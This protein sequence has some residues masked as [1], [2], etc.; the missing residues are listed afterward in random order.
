MLELIWLRGVGGNVLSG[1]GASG[2]EELDW[3]GDSG[4]D[5]VSSSSTGDSVFSLGV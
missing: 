4:G 1:G 3:R 5:G 2:M